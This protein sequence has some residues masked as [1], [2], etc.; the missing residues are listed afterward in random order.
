QTRPSINRSHSERVD[1]RDRRDSGDER[2]Q[3]E[4]ERGAAEPCREPRADKRQ[5]RGYLGVLNVATAV[6][7]REHAAERVS[8]RDPVRGELVAEQR[9][10]SDD[11]PQH[12][13]EDG[14]GDDRGGPAS[15]IAK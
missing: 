10:L 1:E 11:Y 3:T 13:P 8:G 9:L 4:E 6:E 5:R 15:A 7:Q 14:Q 12:R 2:R